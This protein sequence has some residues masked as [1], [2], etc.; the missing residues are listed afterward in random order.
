MWLKELKTHSNPDIKIF[1]IGNKLD[2]EDKRKVSREN[3]QKLKDDYGFDYFEEVSAKTKIN[4]KE[5]FVKAAK[6]LY[7]EYLYYKL[8]KIIK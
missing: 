2:L 6:I 4:T 8:K 3:A 1:L 5:I 7:Q